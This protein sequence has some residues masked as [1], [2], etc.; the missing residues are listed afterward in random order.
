MLLINRLENLMQRAIQ[1]DDVITAKPEIKH[2]PIYSVSQ[3]LF[4]TA[5]VFDRYNGIDYCF[6]NGFGKILTS[7][8]FV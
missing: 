6:P 2:N 7:F 1:L 4:G 8:Y 5:S 3:I